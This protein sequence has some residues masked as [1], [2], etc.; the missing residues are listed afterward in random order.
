MGTGTR[1]NCH[2]PEHVPDQPE[3]CSRVPSSTLGV[4]RWDAG[5]TGAASLGKPGRMG[6]TVGISHATWLGWGLN[7]GVHP[8][9]VQESQVP[10]TEPTGKLPVPDAGSRRH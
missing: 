7:P 8:L 6:S 9:D 3:G 5:P 10:L 4:T 2:R 1:F